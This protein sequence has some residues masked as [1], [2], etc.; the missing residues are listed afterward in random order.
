M[1]RCATKAHVRGTISA[2][3]HTGILTASDN[4]LSFLPLSNVVDS[5]R[6]AEL[7][8]IFDDEQSLTPVQQLQGS[9]IRKWLTSSDVATVELLGWSKGTINPVANKT[10]ITMLG[11]LL[12]CILVIGCYHASCIALISIP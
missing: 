4:T 2:S 7:Q 11:A 8:M 1:T 3:S 10:Y 12:V 6:L 5:D 9:F